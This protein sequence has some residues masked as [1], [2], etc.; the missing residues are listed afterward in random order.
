MKVSWPTSRISSSLI[1]LLRHQRSTRGAYRYTIRSHASRS[2]P[3]ARS[4]RLID[5]GGQRARLSGTIGSVT[6]GL[7]GPL[8]V[9]FWYS[10]RR[11]SRPYSQERSGLSRIERRSGKEFPK[12]KGQRT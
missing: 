12:R 10:C 11:E 6:D 3:I 5:V 4:R 9:P 7:P 1:D 2:P 8:A